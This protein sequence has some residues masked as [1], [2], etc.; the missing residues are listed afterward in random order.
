MKEEFKLQII[1]MSS[2]NS[3]STLFNSMVLYN[4]ARDT[5]QGANI[6]ETVILKTGKDNDFLTI[7]KSN[8]YVLEFTRCEYQGVQAAEAASA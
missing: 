1:D 5:Y 3:H 4:R 6:G 2:G 7:I 8:N